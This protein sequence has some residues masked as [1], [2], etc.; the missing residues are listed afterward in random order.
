MQDSYNGKRASKNKYSIQF[1]YLSI[2]SHYPSSGAIL[3]ITKMEERL[4][5]YLLFP[6]L[7]YI[8]LLVLEKEKKERKRE[9]H[10]FAVLLIYASIV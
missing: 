5:F 10:H 2:N 3:S 7:I 9:K 8:C 6:Y 1:L 4:Y